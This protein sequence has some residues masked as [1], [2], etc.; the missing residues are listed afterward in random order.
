MQADGDHVQR[1]RH[2]AKRVA[3]DPS[4]RRT[5]VHKPRQRGGACAH[6]L[7]Q[8]RQSVY[9]SANR[10]NR[11]SKQCLTASLA[12]TPTNWPVKPRMASSDR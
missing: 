10:A 8:S 11:A 4:D 12:T 7:G 3:D 9:F 2:A 6:L 1:L 5:R